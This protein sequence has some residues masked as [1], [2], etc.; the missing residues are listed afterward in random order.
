[1]CGF[2][3]CWSLFGTLGAYRIKYNGKMFCSDWCLKNYKKEF[4]MISYKLINDSDNT[5][6]RKKD[7]AYE[8]ITR[9]KLDI[10]QIIEL[11]KYGKTYVDKDAYIIINMNNY[12]YRR[13]I[14]E[15]YLKDFVK[16]YIAKELVERL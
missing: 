8:I 6:Y 5:F 1:M 14:K 10:R 12:T 3:N 16:D 4:V 2:K 9:Y 7:N 11:F 13:Q 15:T